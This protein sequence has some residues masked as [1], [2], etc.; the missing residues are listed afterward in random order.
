MR[1]KSSAGEFA[2]QVFVRSVPEN[3]TIPLSTVEPSENDQ[4]QERSSTVKLPH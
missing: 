3:R 4:K 1:A 2:F